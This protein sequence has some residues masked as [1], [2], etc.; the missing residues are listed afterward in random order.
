MMPRQDAREAAKAADCFGV[1][2]GEAALSEGES[3]F[4][5][6]QQSTLGK[7]VAVALG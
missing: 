3:H 5:E 7:R 2:G 1:L 4:D 6:S